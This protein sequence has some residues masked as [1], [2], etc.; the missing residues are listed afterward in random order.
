MSGWPMLGTDRTVRHDRVPARVGPQPTVPLKTA[1]PS[2]C[3]RL[4]CHE[5]AVQTAFHRV[6]GA[7]RMRESGGSLSP[8]CPG[9]M[10]PCPGGREC[11]RQANRTPLLTQMRGKDTRFLSPEP[12]WLWKAPSAKTTPHCQISPHPPSGSHVKILACLR[13]SWQ[14][15][16]A[17]T[18]FH[19]CRGDGCC[20]PP[21]SPSGAMPAPPLGSYHRRRQSC[22]TA[23]SKASLLVARRENT[24]VFCEATDTCIKVGLGLGVRSASCHKW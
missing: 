1:G 10:S 21:L 22:V 23:V 13:N 14:I 18:R 20:W 2:P 16:T 19:L 7:S 9:G 15:I 12:M 8:P 11:G 4:K 17:T 5:D 24:L 3:T 6:T